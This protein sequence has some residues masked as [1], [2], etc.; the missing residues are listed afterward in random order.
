MPKKQKILFIKN[1][2]NYKKFINVKFHTFRCKSDTVR[3]KPIEMFFFNE[4]KFLYG[5]E[6]QKGGQCDD[7]KKQQKKC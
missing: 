5:A 7:R 1:K 3:Y 6:I 4:L 2:N